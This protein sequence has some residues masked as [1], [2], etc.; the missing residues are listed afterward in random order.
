MAFDATTDLHPTETKVK[1][2]ATGAGVAV[3]AIV[4]VLALIDSGDLLPGL[5]D[6]VAVLVS[7]LLAAA[8]SFYSAYSAPHTPRPDLPPV[9]R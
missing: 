9:K 4:T 5:P 8:S 2:G 1:A 6:W 3:T 7:V